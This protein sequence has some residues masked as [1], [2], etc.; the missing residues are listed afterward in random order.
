MP[1]Q[2]GMSTPAPPGESGKPK[3]WLWVT[4]A[5]VLAFAAGIAGGSLALPRL[6]GGPAASASPSPSESERSLRLDRLPKA[7]AGRELV[8]NSPFEAPLKEVVKSMKPAYKDAYGVE[9]FQ[10][11]YR[12]SRGTRYDVTVLA[13]KLPL[14]RQWVQGERQRFSDVNSFVLRTYDKVV[15]GAVP[16]P[17]NNKSDEEIEKMIQTEKSGPIRC[18]R[19]DDDLSVQVDWYSLDDDGVALGKQMTNIAPQIEE[20]FQDVKGG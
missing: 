14:P 17:L 15:C 4:L 2:A 13:G 9:G 6:T 8:D 16:G 19:Q 7:W 20:L 10:V 11:H 3:T 5:A 18:V 12:A 1:P